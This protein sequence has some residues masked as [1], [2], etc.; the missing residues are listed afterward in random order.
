MVSFRIHRDNLVTWFH[1]LWKKIGWPNPQ[2]PAA[3]YAPCIQRA[4]FNLSP[5]RS[6]ELLNRSIDD[7][8]HITRPVEPIPV[9]TSELNEHTIVFQ[10]TN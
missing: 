8:E 1:M 5:S 7:V 9:L 6:R 4:C 10:T 2:N 3:K